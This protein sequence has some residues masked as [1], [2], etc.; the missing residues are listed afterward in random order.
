MA[1]IGDDC[2]ERVVVE[3]HGGRIHILKWSAGL[4]SS[5]L[6]KKIISSYRT[7]S[8]KAVFLDRDGTINDSRPHGYV[9]RKEEWKFLPGVIPALRKL[10]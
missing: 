7:P 10:S 8:I 1:P 4:S 2:L 5:N 3:R 6:I 9:H